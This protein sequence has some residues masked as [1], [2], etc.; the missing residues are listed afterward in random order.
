MSSDGAMQLSH[1]I[2]FN[3][4]VLARYHRDRDFDNIRTVSPDTAV[5]LSSHACVLSPE[6]FV[7]HDNNNNNT[8]EHE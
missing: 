7:W 6:E 4:S 8:I 3:I 5:L 2:A 1:P